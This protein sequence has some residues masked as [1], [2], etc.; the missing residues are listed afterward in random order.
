MSIVG[1]FIRILRKDCLIEFFSGVPGAEMCMH[2]IRTVRMFSKDS[3]DSH[4]RHSFIVDGNACL[5]Y[6]LYNK[7]QKKRQ[8]AFEQVVCRQIKDGGA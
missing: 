8:A 6:N 3:Q 4:N 5:L 1:G 7:R 2:G